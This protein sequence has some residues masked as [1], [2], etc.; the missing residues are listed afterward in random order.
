MHI[1]ANLSGDGRLF[2][3]V[4]LGKNL[5]EGNDILA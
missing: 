2:D 4:R 5:G 1:P 3:A